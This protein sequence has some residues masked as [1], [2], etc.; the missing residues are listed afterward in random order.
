MLAL[1][2]KEVAVLAGRVGYE[3]APARPH[4]LPVEFDGPCGAGDDVVRSLCS[5]SLMRAQRALEFAD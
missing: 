3:P 5:S 2:R 4:V 1:A